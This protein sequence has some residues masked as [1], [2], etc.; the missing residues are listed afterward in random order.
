M[1]SE[2]FVV[3]Q[4]WM[5]NELALKGNELLVFALIYGF[6]QD[7]VSTFQ[8]GR[9]YISDTFNISLPTVDKALK[10]LLSKNYIEKQSSNDYIHTD[11]YWVNEEVVKKLYEGSKETLLGGSKETLLSNIDNRK[12]KNIISNKLDISESV[13]KMKKDK[14]LL[15][16][17]I[18]Q[19]PRKSKKQNLY[20]KCEE[21]IMQYTN[22]IVLQE[23]LKEYLNL[24]L[25]I[26]RSDGKLFYQNMWKGLLNDLDRLTSDT[27]IAIQI[28]E[29]SIRKGWRGFFELKSNKSMSLSPAEKGVISDKK[30]DEELELVDEVY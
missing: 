14:S 19:T 23:K 30:T 28:V 29:Q 18:L 24:R 17:V 6:S 9:Q 21:E 2:N 10:D 25:E 13:E 22:N 11:V 12:E 8:G 15:P 26:A 4:G 5:C 20:Q 7:N 3:I 27:N 16:N 1:K